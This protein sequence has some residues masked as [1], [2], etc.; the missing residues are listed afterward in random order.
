ML[1]ITSIDDLSTSQSLEGL[2]RVK[3]VFEY[4]GTNFSGYQIQPEKRTVQGEVEKLLSAFFG[5]PIKIYASG[6]TDAGVHSLGQTAHFDIK[7]DRINTTQLVNY[8]NKHLPK[9]ISIRDAE[10]VSFE[11]DSRFSVEKKTYVYKFYLSRYERAV[12]KDLA[13][14]VNDN[15]NVE[16]M[17]QACKYLV[18]THDF[19][20][21]VARKSGKNDFVRTIY[22]AKISS[23]GDGVFEFEVTGNGFLYNMV[24]IIMGTLIDVGSGR[25]NPKDIE[26]IIN[27]QN[28][29]LAGKTVP[30]HGLYMKG[31]QYGNLKQ[32]VQN[33]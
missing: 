8:L 9:D 10:E 19:R 15:I 7:R 6:R 1:D 12:Y 32:V 33:G 23:I 14:R 28:R 5:E 25:K 26:V 29:S 11:F 20:S 24:R 4:L 27:G 18:G 16:K 21:F 31:V 3:I 13:L 22:D 2:K 17:M 30:P